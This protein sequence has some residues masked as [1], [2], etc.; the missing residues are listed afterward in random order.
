MLERDSVC[1]LLSA[2][3]LCMFMS[4]CM[5]RHI[6]VGVCICLLAIFTS[7][8]FFVIFFRSAFSYN[9]RQMSRIYP[10]GGRVDSSNFMPQVID[11]SVYSFFVFILYFCCFQAWI[12]IS[13]NESV[14]CECV[15]F[16]PLLLLQIFWNTGCQMVALNFQTPDLAMQLNQG[17]FEY[18]G[19]CGYAGSVYSV[20]LIMF[21]VSEFFTVFNRVQNCIVCNYMQQQLLFSARLNHRNSVCPS[22]CPS[23][24]RLDQ[25]NK[26]QARIT[27]SSPSAAWK[28]LVSGTVKLSHKFERG[29]PER[30]C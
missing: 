5:M 24:A 6:C 18:N 26:V 11:H 7:V 14:F 19:N 10:K 8:Q 28:T 16:S 1:Y 13:M 29:Y 20:I 4:Q 25:S 27:K 2:A 22:I 15:E 3:L 21:T 23:V 9:K 12:V 30:G 17:K